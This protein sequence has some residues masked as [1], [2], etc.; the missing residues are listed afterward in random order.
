MAQSVESP[1][2]RRRYARLDIALSV[3]YVVRDESGEVT[4]MAEAMSSDISATGIRLMTPTPL[5]NGATLDL[6]IT[7]EGQDSEPVMASCEVVWQNQISDSSYEVG[8]IIRYIEEDD[9]KRFLDFV[10]RQLSQ[11]VGMPSSQVH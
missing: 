2:E 4:E 6:E 9:K 10:F 3:N 8:A 1:I 5:D 11:L 7:I